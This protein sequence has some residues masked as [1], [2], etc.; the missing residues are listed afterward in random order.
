LPYSILI[1][2]DSTLVRGL[3]RSYIEPDAAWRVCGE[4]ENGEVAVEK[5]KELHPDVVILDFQMPVMNGLE[6][7]RRI[8]L[9]A[10]NT[11][12]VMLTMHDCE[13]L[14]K[15]AQAAGIKEVLSKSDGIAGHLIASLRSVVKKRCAERWNLTSSQP[16]EECAMQ[17]HNPQELPSD[18]V[19]LMGKQIESL[20]KETFVGLTAAE[21]QEYEERQHRID[22]LCEDLRYLHPAA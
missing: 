2:D 1:V 11:T 6:A 21:R 5:V 13:Q 18:L 10:P 19:Q 16:K 9:L 17:Y 15:D 4:A 20:E 22:E 3:I 7:A 12:M 14:S 8:T